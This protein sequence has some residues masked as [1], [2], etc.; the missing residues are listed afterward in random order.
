[1]GRCSGASC[2]SALRVAAEI[3]RLHCLSRGQRLVEHLRPHFIDLLQ[4][5]AIVLRVEHLF[6]NLRQLLPVVPIAN[7]ILDHAQSV[8]ELRV[9][10]LGQLQQIAQLLDLDAEGMEILL[11]QHGPAVELIDEPHRRLPAGTLAGGS[12]HSAGL[13]CVAPLFDLHG[14]LLQ[15]AASIAALLGDRVEQFAGAFNAHGTQ[16]IDQAGHREVAVIPVEAARLGGQ[17][18][19]VAHVAR[20][21]AH[22]PDRLQQ[23]A[24]QL[25]VAGHQRGGNRFDPAR[26]GAQ[27]V[28]V[29]DWR[30]TGEALQRFAQHAN[31]FPDVAEFQFH[32]PQG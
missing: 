20:G 30:L 9:C 14:K 1:M 21:L 16:V 31:R 2:L 17:Y 12:G 11:V 25:A 22:G 5:R 15:A 8:H 32:S 18:I 23:A 4:R 29:F 3:P 10:I 19:H 6:R 26:A 24:R 28:N 13:A 7:S 27:I